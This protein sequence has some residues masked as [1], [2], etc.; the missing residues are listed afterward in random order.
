PMATYQALI[1]QGRLKPDQE[2]FR[3]VKRLQTL[4]EELVGYTPPEIEVLSDEKK[5]HQQPLSPSTE[6]LSSANTLTRSLIP[7][8]LDSQ[9]PEF[10]G[11]RGLWIHGSVGSGK[12]LLMNLFH[13]S[14]PTPLK[15][16]IHFHHFMQRVYVLIQDWTRLQQEDPH[17]QDAAAAAAGGR[18][19]HVTEVVARELVKRHGWLWC[20]DEF[21]VPD[22]ASAVL[23]RQVLG[24]MVRLGVVMVFTSNRVPAD[25]YKAGFQRGV[26]GPFVE[27]LEERCEVWG[28]RGGKDFREVMR[29]EQ[30]VG[31]G[32]ENY[33]VTNSE[34]S[35]KAFTKVTQPT[36]L[37][38]YSRP[39]PIPHSIPNP[40]TALFPFSTLCGSSTSPH[41]PFGPADYL[42][43]ASHFET[44]IVQNVPVMGLKEKN[45]ARRFIWFLDAAYENRVRVVVSADAEPEGLFV[46]RDEEKVGKEEKEGGDEVMHR[47]MLG[48]LMGGFEVVRKQG[49][50]KKGEKEGGWGEMDAYEVRKLAIVTGEDEKFAFKRAVSRLKEMSSIAY[51]ASRIAFEDD[52]MEGKDAAA[53]GGHQPVFLDWTPLKHTHHSTVSDFSQPPPPPNSSTSPSA[54]PPLRSTPFIFNPPTTTTQPPPP[55]S[56]VITP[57]APRGYHTPPLNPPPPTDQR[58]V[59]DDM[60]AEAGYT[61]HSLQLAQRMQT[62][63]E[64]GAL[65]STHTKGGTVVK[66]VVVD[67]GKGAVPKF[68]EVHFWGVGSWG[69][70]GGKWGMGVRAFWS[71]IVNGPPGEGEGKKGGRGKKE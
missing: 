70:R 2:Q 57:D 27:M 10:I 15:T 45:E 71:N 65:S 43:L 1:A 61:L 24:C 62:Y 22:V 11:P 58:G 12:T 6:P 38:I 25:L 17:Q 7:I 53:A 66:G 9:P 48:D 41:P 42:H 44:I 33:F 46:V 35:V 28:V 30:P 5:Q 36:T 18:K 39:L 26:Y 54:P 68:K 63:L 21:Q 3:T 4:C 16:R 49:K 55:P 51:L 31:E 29:E 56:A 40:P 59:V 34:E 69:E 64:P 32:E 13:D 8:L 67:E 19:L 50:A 23:M 20:F 14:F 47:E 52:K 37:Q 60:G